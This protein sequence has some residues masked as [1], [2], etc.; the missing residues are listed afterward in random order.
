MCTNCGDVG[1]EIC[2]GCPECGEYRQAP[3]PPSEA[4]EY[5]NEY[6]GWS[7]TPRKPAETKSE[8]EELDE[9]LAALYDY[10]KNKERDP[11]KLERLL[12]KYKR[13][14]GKD[15]PAFWD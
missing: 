6:D 5:G 7:N 10:R 12:V 9:T 3:T 15:K 8:Q 13:L 11:D 1:C 14:T 2:G 4:L